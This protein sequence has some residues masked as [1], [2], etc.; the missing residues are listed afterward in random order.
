M[1]AVTFT[2]HMFSLFIYRSKYAAEDAEK[3]ILASQ[4]FN[5]E[6]KIKLNQTI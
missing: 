3:L 6:T 1:K 2:A 4:H 5:S